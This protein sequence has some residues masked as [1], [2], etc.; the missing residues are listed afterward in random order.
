MIINPI[1]GIYLGYI[2]LL[3]AGL[4]GHFC[5]C[6]FTQLLSSQEVA[7]ISM[8]NGC[9]CL[10]KYMSSQCHEITLFF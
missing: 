1:I 8:I 4:L 3:E 2:F 10:D 5:S 7:T 9:Y 6:H